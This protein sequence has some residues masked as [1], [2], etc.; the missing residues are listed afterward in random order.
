MAYC[1][2]GS[3]ICSTNSIEALIWFGPINLLSPSI[4]NSLELCADHKMWY[5]RWPPNTIFTFKFTDTL[6]DESEQNF[7]HA[8][9]GVN[10][11]CVTFEA[12][13]EVYFPPRL[14]PR[15]LDDR[16]QAL[17]VRFRTIGSRRG[18]APRNL[19]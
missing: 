13:R 1:T 4:Q 9:K 7:Y 12:P 3:K 11:S 17:A 2:N 8:K 15:W 16:Q 18:R 19:G 14:S 5:C 6:S 10:G